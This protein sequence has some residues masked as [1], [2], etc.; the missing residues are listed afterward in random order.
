[1][2]AA[3]GAIMALVDTFFEHG[4]NIE[5]FIAKT[6]LCMLNLT[7]AEAVP[8]DGYIYLAIKPV[9]DHE[10]CKQMDWSLASQSLFY[11]A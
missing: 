4:M 3:E 7:K 8:Y 1:M 9:F 10:R 6:P 2:L 5:E 11:T